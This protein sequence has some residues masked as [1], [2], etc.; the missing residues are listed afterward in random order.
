MLKGVKKIKQKNNKVFLVVQHLS[1]GGL[2]IMTLNLLDQLR[3]SK[4]LH[5]ISLENK[6]TI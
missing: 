1:P 6:P 2:E 4:D 5:I 3:D